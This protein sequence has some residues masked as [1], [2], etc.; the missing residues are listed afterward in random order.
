MVALVICFVLVLPSLFAVLRPLVQQRIF[1]WQVWLI[2]LE[3][4]IAPAGT[5]LAW[6]VSPAYSIAYAVAT[7]LTVLVFYAQTVVGISDR[8][9]Q[10]T[11]L[12]WVAATMSLVATAIMPRIE[13]WPPPPAPP[14]PKPVDLTFIS[15]SIRQMQ[16]SIS[17]ASDD[18]RAEQA[19]IEES[20]QL[21]LD[22]V[23]H[24]N[25][26]VEAL[27]RERDRLANQVAQQQAIVALTDEQVDAIHSQLQR[28]KYFDYVVGFVFGVVASL[29]ASALTSL[30]RFRRMKPTTTR[31]GS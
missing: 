17:E 28:G 22:Q 13:N 10:L 15:A 27:A 30:K 14:A 11:K 18:I 26:L 12:L 31:V 2:A 29:T 23:D 1:N 8:V 25:R 7:Y 21:L 9:H 20:T 4:G 3:I 24:Q 5:Y 19:K 6:Q 16:R